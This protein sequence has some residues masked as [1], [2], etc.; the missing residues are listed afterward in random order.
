MYTTTTTTT[1]TKFVCYLE[2][3]RSSLAD[4]PGHIKYFLRKSPVSLPTPSV[5]VTGMLMIVT[6]TGT[7]VFLSFTT[8]IM[9]WPSLSF[10]VTLG[11]PNPTFTSTRSQCNIE[12]W[13]SRQSRGEKLPYIDILNIQFVH[14]QT[15]CM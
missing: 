8:H 6:I 3:S 11:R 5:A 9:N 12:T 7:T 10:T 14:S 13:N 15:L 4:V 1:T 2:I